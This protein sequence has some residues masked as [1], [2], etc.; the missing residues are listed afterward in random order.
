LTLS[1]VRSTQREPKADGSTTTI[2]DTFD[3]RGA[4]DLAAETSRTAARIASPDIFVQSAF[5][6]NT[7]GSVTFGGDVSHELGARQ[8]AP[9]EGE[10][11]VSADIDASETPAV[12]RSLG[13]GGAIRVSG[14]WRSTQ[15]NSADEVNNPPTTSLSM[16]PQYTYDYALQSRPSC[17]SYSSS[18]MP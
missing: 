14:G 5:V 12:Q 18:G 6:E 17:L 4:A 13:A 7:A 3:T 2:R 1:S 16:V 9:L 15:S 8:D 11:E 10:I